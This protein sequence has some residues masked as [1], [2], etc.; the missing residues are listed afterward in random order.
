MTSRL[1][2]PPDHLPRLSP[3]DVLRREAYLATLQLWLEDAD[4]PSRRRQALVGQ[5][6]ADLTEDAAARGLPRALHDLGPARDLA[7]TYLDIEGSYRPRW[8][9]GV[10]CAGLFWSACVLA[11]AIYLAGL[12]DAASSAGT[13]V[14]GR[15]L[16]AAIEAG[17]Q[18]VSLTVGTPWVLLVGLALFLVAARPW[19][20]LPALRRRHERRTASTG[21]PG[22]AGVEAT[23]PATPDA[24]AVPPETTRG[25][26]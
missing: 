4:Y 13:R 14:D 21:E 6:R 20:A 7:R 25:A 22:G 19:R 17:E 5:L 15:F 26:R 23:S 11:T 8:M 10:A 18:S 2:D 1:P 3:P 12:L 24:A 16:G 9:R